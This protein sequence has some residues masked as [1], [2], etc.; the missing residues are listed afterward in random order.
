[1]K[2]VYARLE[3]D[4]I[5]WNGNNIGDIFVTLGDWIKR[6]EDSF[7]NISLSCDMESS[8]GPSFSMYFNDSSYEINLHDWIVFD[9]LGNLTVYN[10]KDFN[11]LFVV[12]D[13]DL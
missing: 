11:E 3:V 9:S 6:I 13:D 10:S 1:M 8:R 12:L 4:A 2:F 5:Q 7:S